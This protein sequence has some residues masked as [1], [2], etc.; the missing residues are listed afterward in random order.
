V[1]FA[2]RVTSRAFGASRVTSIVRSAR[3]DAW[4]HFGGVDRIVRLSGQ[5]AGRGPAHLS[6]SQKRRT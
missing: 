1:N 5:L 3:R 2:A 4:T 6:R